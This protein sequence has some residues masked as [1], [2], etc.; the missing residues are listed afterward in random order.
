[1]TSVHANACDTMTRGPRTRDVCRALIV[2]ALWTAASC[3]PA[4]SGR[5]TVTTERTEPRRR[6][7]S[8]PEAQW[9]RCGC[10]PGVR[11]AIDIIDGSGLKENSR[12]VLERC[13]A[14]DSSS[15]VSGLAAVQASLSGCAKTRIELNPSANAA[16]AE[17]AKVLATRPASPTEVCNWNR[18]VY[19]P[20]ARCAGDRRVEICDGIDNDA[21]GQIDEDARDAQVWYRDDDGDGVGVAG[22]QVR[23]CNVVSGYAKTPG[24]CC[25]RDARVFPGQTQGFEQASACGDHDYDCDGRSTPLVNSQVARC[26]NAWPECDQ[27]SSR[28]WVRRPPAQCGATAPYVVSCVEGGQMSCQETRAPRALPCR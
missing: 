4:T 18:C 1:M 3:T 16:I 17:I 26:P 9:T 5:S 7:V 10:H 27:P 14:E 25:D 20:S 28:G 15:A 11:S 21:D 22:E 6:C 8:M 23:S 19:G 12:R 24:D 2:G 13:I